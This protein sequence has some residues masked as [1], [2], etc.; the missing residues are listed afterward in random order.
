MTEVEVLRRW[1]GSPVN[2]RTENAPGEH[3]GVPD[4]LADELA[5]MSPPCVRILRR[6][7]PATEGIGH[8]GVMGSDKTENTHAVLIDLVRELVIELRTSRTR[9]N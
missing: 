4:E 1:R 9:K 7:V 5:A 3:C 8:D 6:N 2:A